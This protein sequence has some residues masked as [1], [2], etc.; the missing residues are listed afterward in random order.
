MPAAL[1]QQRTWVWVGKRSLGKKN[2]V[3]PSA[4]ALY[5][6]VKSTPV[7]LSSFSSAL[8]S[9]SFGLCEGASH[10]SSSDARSTSHNYAP[11][12]NKTVGTYPRH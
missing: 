5:M 10:V 9:A 8:A 4:S 11:G 12:A 7:G 6:A 3:E 1:R 2:W